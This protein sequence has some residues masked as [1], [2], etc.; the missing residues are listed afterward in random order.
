MLDQGNSGEA[1]EG[2]GGQSLLMRE[3]EGVREQNII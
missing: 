2:P 1:A 3:T